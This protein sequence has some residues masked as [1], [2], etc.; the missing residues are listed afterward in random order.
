[1]TEMV[2]V[3]DETIGSGGFAD[4]RSGRYMG[5]PAA[6]K[7]TNAGPRSDLQ[8]IRKVCISGLVC[9]HLRR[10]LNGPAPAILQGC[11]PLE[12]A[13]PSKHPE[14]C[15]CSGRHKKAPIR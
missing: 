8:R 15:W 11:H 12:Y 2:E 9:F 1:M 6:V 13:I 3:S 7:T 10:Y 14:A 5:H 4:V